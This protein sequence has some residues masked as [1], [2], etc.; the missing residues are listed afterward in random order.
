[1]NEE[2]KRLRNIILRQY[3]QNGIK[4]KSGEATVPDDTDFIVSG[5][6]KECNLCILDCNDLGIKSNFMIIQELIK[7]LEL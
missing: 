1:M 2:I 6:F 7:K 4:L 5:G 3:Y